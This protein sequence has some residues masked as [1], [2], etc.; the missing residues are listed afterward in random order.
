MIGLVVRMIDG[1]VEQRLVLDDLAALDA[2]GR[3][4]DGLGLAVVDAGRQLM[5]GEAAEHDG[6]DGAQSG[7][8]QH[9][10]DR[11]RDHRHIQDH[12]VALG[13]AKVT[14]RPGEP[15]GQ[16]EQLGIGDGLDGAGDRAVIDDGGLIAAPGFDV[17]IHGVVGCIQHTAL[18]PAVERRVGAVENGIPGLDPVDLAGGIAPKAFGV[19]DGA[20]VKLFITTGHGTPSSY[21]S[22]D[23]ILGVSG[24]LLLYAGGYCFRGATFCKCVSLFK[25][26]A[27]F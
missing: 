7:A 25:Q 11:L 12:P 18:E 23:L 19:R 15:C 24:E 17:A 5:R 10:Y 8:C 3:G 4:D 21:W 13:D 6:M 16:V 9:G 14:Q 1:G 27:T 20:G 22:G 2:A 26:H